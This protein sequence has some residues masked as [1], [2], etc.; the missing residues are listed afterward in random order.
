EA[1]RVWA[2][3]GKLFAALIRKPADGPALLQA[4]ED[5]LAGPPRSVADAPR[6]DGPSDDA[7]A[8][9]Q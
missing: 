5:A 1:D 8:A 6:A 2:A 7:R 9:G 3:H 4:V